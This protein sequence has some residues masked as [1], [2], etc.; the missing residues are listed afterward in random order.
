LATRS[1]TTPSFVGASW[2]HDPRPSESLARA[3]VRS[4]G[5]LEPFTDRAGQWTRHGKE[6]VAGSSPAEGFRN[7]AT[8]RFS[9]SRS[10]SDDHFRTLPS[11]KWSSMAVDRRCVAVCAAAEHVLFAAQGTDAVHA[12]RECLSRPPGER[13]RKR[14]TSIRA[15]PVREPAERARG[16]GRRRALDEGRPTTIDRALRRQERRDR[17]PSMRD[18]NPSA[19]EP[20]P[21]AWCSR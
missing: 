18:D 19:A 14:S 11:E 6:G 2:G 8:A 5:S 16:R 1:L 7:R 4:L 21:C 20:A 9:Y 3:R 13:S 12:R 15:A 10:G 17:G